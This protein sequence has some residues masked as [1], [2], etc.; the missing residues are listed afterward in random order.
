MG[1]NVT[2]SVDNSDVNSVANVPVVE[3]QKSTEEVAVVKSNCLKEKKKILKIVDKNNIL[4]PENYS[5]CNCRVYDSNEEYDYGSKALVLKSYKDIM[6][7]FC[8]HC[9]ND[10]YARIFW[11]YDEC[12][13]E[14]MKER[15]E[16]MLNKATFY[17]RTNMGLKNYPCYV[18]SNNPVECCPCPVCFNNGLL[19][20]SVDLVDGNIP[21]CQYHFDDFQMNTV[22]Y[23]NGYAN[24]AEVNELAK[25][26]EII[27]KHI[28]RKG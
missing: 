23:N 2:T 1:N 17:W 4:E 19:D 13:N 26:N 3:Q 14:I 28:V 15:Y 10:E 18:D 22:P 27:K 9:V 8:R 25:F 21:L 12:K 6:Y 16:N 24:D 20:Y 5:C 11:N 7:P